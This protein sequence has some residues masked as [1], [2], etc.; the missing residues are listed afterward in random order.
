MERIFSKQ[1]TNGIKGL[2]ILFMMFHHCFAT[3]ERFENYAVSFAPL[4]EG[5]G[6]LISHSLKI[7]VGMFVFLSAYGMTISAKKSRLSAKRI[8]DMTTNRL[9]GMM[10]NFMLLFI[11]VE[12]LDLIWGQGRMLTIYGKGLRGLLY[13]AIDFFGISDLL[14]TPT[15]LATWWYMSVAIVLILILPLLLW[16]YRKMG[17]FAI[18]LVAILPY[19]FEIRY[20]N[21]ERYFLVMILGVVFAQEDALVCF[22]KWTI[23]EN[24]LISQ[25]VKAL[26]EIII[27]LVL[28]RAR[29][30]EGAY[31]LIGFYDSLI[32]VVV[33]LFAYE[34][35]IGIPMVREVL[36]FIGRHSMNIFLAHNCFRV[37]WCPDFIYGF[38]SA[39]LIPLVLLLIS[40][41][42][43]V[44]L[45]LLK[46]VI[47]FESFVSRIKKKLIMQEN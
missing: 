8:T 2:A 40:L 13:A 43:S 25:V 3:V 36:V 9:V 27:L 38:R 44:V 4:S 41:A 22:A 26:C 37:F 17:A 12:L 14:G 23:G 15:F 11:V 30:L 1:D 20:E 47:R 28:F 7:C 31:N 34:F 32:P 19:L 29:S 39:W 33:I 45:E 5:L 21:I 10:S 24:R 35:V 6:V 18:V 16:L 46:K 42:F